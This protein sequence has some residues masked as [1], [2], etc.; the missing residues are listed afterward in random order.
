MDPMVDQSRSQ[1]LPQAR[2]LSRVLAKDQ[3]VCSACEGSGEI[4]VQCR[5]AGSVSIPCACGGAAVRRESFIQFCILEAIAVI[6][7]VPIL[8]AYLI[9]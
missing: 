6:L 2:A 5:D 4:W 1:R 7:V 3:Q 8:C 9:Y